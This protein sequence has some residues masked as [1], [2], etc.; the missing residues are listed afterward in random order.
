ME[1]DQS[2]NSDKIV[3]VLLQTSRVKY[4]VCTFRG[5]RD[6]ALGYACKGKY[7]SKFDFTQVEKIRARTLNYL[8]Y[9]TIF[10]KNDNTKCQF[11]ALAITHTLL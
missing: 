8:C 5:L 3:S 7:Y 2:Y 9:W 6:Y 4:N 10:T 1:S 11:V